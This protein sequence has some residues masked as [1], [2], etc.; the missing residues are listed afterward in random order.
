MDA[1]ALIAAIA[2]EDG[3]ENVHKMLNTAFDGDID[4]I[5]NK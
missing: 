1:C 4:I 3:A 5:M 2:G